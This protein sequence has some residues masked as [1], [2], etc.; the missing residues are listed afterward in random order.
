MFL[1]IELLYFVLMIGGF[2]ALLLFAKLPAGLCM[3]VSSLIG[4]IVSAII[5]KTPLGLRYFVEGTF[6]YF[7]TILVITTAMIFIGAMQATG[8]LDYLSVVLVK[9]LLP[10]AARRRSPYRLIPFLQNIRSQRFH[11]ALLCS[12]YSVTLLQV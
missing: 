7:D 4:G 6:G 10:H 9:T 8:A 11:F 2:V 3:M 12:A 5:T 1:Q